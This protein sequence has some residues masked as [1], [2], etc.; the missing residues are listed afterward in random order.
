VRLLY[1]SLS[2]IPSRRAS[3]VHVMRMSSALSRAGHEVELIAK[4][5]TEPSADGLDDFAFY[6]VQPTFRVEKL[7]R[8]AWRGGGVLFAGGIARALAAR[9]NHVDLVYSREPVGAMLAAELRMPVVFESHGIPDERWQRA[10]LRRLARHKSLRGIVSISEALRRDL[11]AADMLPRDRPV[12]IAHDAADPPGEVSLER[13]TR[14]RPRVGYVG[15]LYQG[16]GI[17]LILDVAR[18]LPDH[19]FELVGG[20][21][22]DLARWRAQGL[23]A[24]V[25]LAGFVPPAQLRERYASFDVL[26]MPHPK[27]GVAAA[28]G[29]DIS[30]WTSPMKMFEYMASGTP[31]I[32]SDLP[33]LAEVLHHESNALIA[34]AGDAMAWEQSVRRLCSD[35][36]LARALAERAYRDLV[37]DYTWDARVKKIFAELS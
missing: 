14:G 15:N 32:A 24:N 8:P 29:I 2:Y 3:S 36:P 9:R 12:V 33:V 19:D 23:P 30:R 11:L 25:V 16:R 4:R 13:P 28:T 26:L 1:L 31:I 6:G 17:E 20:N 22:Q 21:E 27:K 7:A 37:R 35:R 5:S 34:P 18:R 10:L